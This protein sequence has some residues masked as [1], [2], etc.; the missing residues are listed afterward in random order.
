MDSLFPFLGNWVWFVA[1]GVFLLLELLSVPL[2]LLEQGQHT[3]RLLAVLTH[4]SEHLLLLLQQQ[5]LLLLLLLHTLL[6][7]LTVPLLL[8][9]LLCRLAAGSSHCEG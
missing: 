8:R 9:L 7:P 1:A 6:L 4:A 3:R 2:A 5:L